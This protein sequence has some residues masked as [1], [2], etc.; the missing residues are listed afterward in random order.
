MRLGNTYKTSPLYGSVSVAYGSQMQPQVQRLIRMKHTVFWQGMMEDC[1]P[2]SHSSHTV[3][4]TLT[5]T[6]RTCM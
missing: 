5:P 3:G 2:E 4:V 6:S 1:L